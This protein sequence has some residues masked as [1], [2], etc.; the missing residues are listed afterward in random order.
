M[1]Q[2][3]AAILIT[4][5]ALVCVLLVGLN[6]CVA[7]L[8]ARMWAVAVQATHTARAHG[9]EADSTQVTIQAAT[10]ALEDVRE[11]VPRG[12]YRPPTDAEL[13]DQILAER[14]EFTTTAN[15]GIEESEPIPSG[16]FYKAPA[17]F[18]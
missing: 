1:N 2:I 17:E 12:D 4:A 7:A 11:R 13:M 18:D 3:L 8:G 10:D 5:A 6:V 14:G 9:A 16:G 15:E